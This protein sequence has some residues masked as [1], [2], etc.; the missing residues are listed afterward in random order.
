MTP[1]PD[2]ELLWNFEKFVVSRD[3]RVVGRFTS[4]TVPD[5]PALVS[6]IDAELRK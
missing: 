1:N 4:D 6:L 3:G 2:P 5:N